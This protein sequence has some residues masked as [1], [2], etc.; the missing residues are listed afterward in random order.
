MRALIYNIR[1]FGE[2]GSRTQLKSYIRGERVDIIG[3][4]ETIKSEFSATELRSLEFGGQFAWNWLPVEGHSGVC[5]SV[6]VMS[7]LMSERGGRGP[8]SSRLPYSNGRT[9]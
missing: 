5:F 7:V 3:L 2:Q 1:G 8:S 4:Q 6:S 9:I